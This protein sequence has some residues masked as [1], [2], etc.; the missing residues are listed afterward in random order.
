MSSD[1][2][3]HAD[4]VY[5]HEIPHHDPEEGFDRTEPAVGAIWGFAIGSVVLLILIIVAL[6]GYFEEL[7]Q[8]AV[9]DNILVAPSSQLQTVRDRDAWNLSHYMYGDH[10]ETSGRVRIPIDKA[11]EM[12]AQEAAGG[13]LFYPAKA[14]PVKPQEPD[15]G[16]PKF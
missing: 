5:E 14:A 2:H 15:P 13:R 6:Q 4:D 12:F 7:Y 9:H 11:M 3:K 10:K 8:Q 1:H 16:A